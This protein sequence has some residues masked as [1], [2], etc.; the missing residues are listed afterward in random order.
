MNTENRMKMLRCRRGFTLI[1]LMVV[2]II[3]GMLAALVVPRMFGRIGQA[4]QKAAYAQIELFGTALDSFRLD[5][6]RYPTSAEG[7]DALISQVSGADDWNGPYLKKNEI[8]PDPWNNPYHYE[9]PGRNGDYDLYSYG[10]DNAEGGDG[11]DEDIV[12]W[13]S[14][15]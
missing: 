12:S 7:L 10:A 4:K 2:M 9:S 8:P 13:K 6:G 14:S 15:R 5:V 1:E 3:L 11:E